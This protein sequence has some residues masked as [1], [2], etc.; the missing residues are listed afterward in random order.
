MSKNYDRLGGDGSD[1]QQVSPQSTT[2]QIAAN[3]MWLAVK[4]LLIDQE[5]SE[6][7]M[8]MTEKAYYTNNP[9]PPAGVYKVLLEMN[10]ALNNSFPLHN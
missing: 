10:W 7:W 1:F 6:D 2:A 4:N 5:S 9:N 3:A 8:L